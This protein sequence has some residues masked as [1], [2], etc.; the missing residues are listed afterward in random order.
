VSISFVLSFIIGIPWGACGVA[1][2]YTV[3][4]Y[5]IMIPSLWY[6]FRHTPVSVLGFFK[7]ISGPVITSITATAIMFLAYEFLL[8]GRSDIVAIGTCLVLGIASYFIMW[9]LM[10]GGIHTIRE[11]FS[12][13]L[14]IV[15]GEKAY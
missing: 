4:Q 9:V 8:A 1:L 14:L 6:S 15:R 7:T 10:P 13:V 3:S 12:Y 2:A 5:L 11:L